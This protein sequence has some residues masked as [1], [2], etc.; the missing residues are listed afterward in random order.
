MKKKV[1]L[2][3]ASGKL[4]S[5]LR[6]YLSKDYNLIPIGYKK[7]PKNGYKLDLTNPI[8]VKKFLDKINPNIVVHLVSMTNVDLCEKEKEKGLTFLSH[9]PL[10]FPGQAWDNSLSL[11]EYT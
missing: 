8:K 3:G 1:L 7:K 6:K 9:D 4:G 5:I 11:R 2:T 10:D